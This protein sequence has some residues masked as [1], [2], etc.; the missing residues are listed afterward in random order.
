MI[1]APEQPFND[2]ELGTVATTWSA[3]AA[4][5]SRSAQVKTGLEL[6]LE[7]MASGGAKHRR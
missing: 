5:S 1:M 7:S 2:A 4:C 3:A 6:L